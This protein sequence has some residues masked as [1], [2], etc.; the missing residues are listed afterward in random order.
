MTG[1]GDRATVAQAFDLALARSWDAAGVSSP[2]PPVGAVILD[3]DEVV[4]GIGSTQPVGGPHAEIMAL[5]QAGDAARGGT[6]VVTLEPCDHTGR[7][8]PCTQALIDA[9][10][11][12]VQFAVAD[13]DPEAAGGAQTLRAAGIDVTS[14]IGE[15]AAREGPLRAWLFRQENGRPLITVKTA[16]TLDGR[17]A[18]PDGTSRWITGDA[19]REHAHAQRARLD[20][21]VVGTGTALADDPAL[22][23]RQPDG[24]LY[25]HQPTRVVLGNRELPDDARLLDDSAPFLQVRSHNPADVI[26]A[27]PDALW[28]LIEGGPA[29]IGAFLAAGLVDEVQAYLAP[30]ILGGGEPSVL[31][32]SVATLTDLHRFRRTGVTELG[33]DLLITLAR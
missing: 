23:A 29:I 7:T 15:R 26:A 25:P 11:A 27:L 20:A 18:A 31:D 9:G 21:I 6:A 30:A 10:I 5:R 33:A 1:I 17:I 32:D 12:A 22:T 19:A 14:G 3:A 4:A 24:S 2:N 16:S 8:G 28:V 13:P